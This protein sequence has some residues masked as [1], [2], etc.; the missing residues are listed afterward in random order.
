MQL[1]VHLVFFYKHNPYI[2]ICTYIYIDNTIINKSKKAVF[3]LSFVCPLRSLGVSD[4]REYWLKIQSLQV[5]G[6]IQ[7]H[8]PG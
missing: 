1:Q 8:T 2:Y 3:F 6:A 7:Q 5:S 4:Q